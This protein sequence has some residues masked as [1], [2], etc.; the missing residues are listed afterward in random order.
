MV[1]LYIPLLCK[2]GAGNMLGWL[3]CFQCALTGK[4]TFFFFSLMKITL[5]TFL[6]FV[7][8]SR[9]FVLAMQPDFIWSWDLLKINLCKLKSP[10]K[11]SWRDRRSKLNLTLILTNM[12]LSY[13]LKHKHWKHDGLD[14]CPYFCL[15]KVFVLLAWAGDYWWS[16]YSLFC[17]CCCCLFIAIPI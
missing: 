5:M 10:N 8:W 3:V 12:F 15:F 2:G 13:V 4:V 1:F 11:S 14:S 9:I 7:F 16:S 6:F 17:C